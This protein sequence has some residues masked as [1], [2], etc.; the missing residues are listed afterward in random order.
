M[1]IDQEQMVLLSLV[2]CT[3]NQA[4]ITGERL[5][6]RS[7]ERLN[8][9]LEALGGKWTRKVKAHVFEGDAQTRLDLAI[10]TGQVET[11]RDLGWFPTPAP[12]AAELVERCGVGPG[13]RV[14]EPSAG[15]GAIVRALLN[16]TTTVYACEIDEERAR[17]IRECFPPVTLYV[18]DFM[19]FGVEDDAALFDHVV[20]NP[21]FCKVGIGDHLDHVCYAFNRVRR[22]GRLVSVLPS[23][24]TFREDRRHR[25]FREWAKDA[26]GGTIEPLPPGSFSGSGTAVNTV[27][28]TM[29]RAA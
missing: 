20:M 8:K 11:A 28:L 13:D 24:V 19:T 27:V 5:D 14:L 17:V 2:T 3:G 16:R 10:T 22:G 12:L 25:A 7:Y 1:K 4:V 15:T 29:T 9:V 21:P 26:H 18:G 23:S 6:R